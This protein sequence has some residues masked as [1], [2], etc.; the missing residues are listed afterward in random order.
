MGKLIYKDD[1]Q[2]TETMRPYFLV[3]GKEE[4]MAEIICPNIDFEAFV[5]QNIIINH[6]G[7]KIQIHIHYYLIKD[8][9]LIVICSGLGK[10]LDIYLLIFI[11]TIYIWVFLKVDVIVTYVI[12]QKWNAMTLNLFLKTGHSKSTETLIN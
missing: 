5:H 2:S 9:K 11:Y 6:R 8:G 1:L 4:Q 12:C 10:I 3:P 7:A